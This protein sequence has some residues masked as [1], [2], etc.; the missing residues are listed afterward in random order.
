MRPESASELY[1]QSDRRLS[2]K[3]VPTYA[4]RVPR[5][6]RDRSPWSYSRISRPEPLFFFQIAPQLYSRGWVDPVPDP[7]CFFKAPNDSKALPEFNRLLISSWIRFWFVT[8]VPKYLNCDIFSNDLF[9]IFTSRFWPTF[10]WRV[11][12]SSLVENIFLEYCLYGP[13]LWIINYWT[14]IFCCNNTGLKENG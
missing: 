2:A 9:A 12:I 4:D 8:V 6:Q 7:L 1:Q 10:W 11:S 5:S 14:N 13:L 3:L